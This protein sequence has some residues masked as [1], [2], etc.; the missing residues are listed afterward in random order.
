MYGRSCEPSE[1]LLGTPQH[2]SYVYITNIRKIYRVYTTN[3]LR[4]L[5]VYTRYILRILVYLKSALYS[6]QNEGCKT[7]N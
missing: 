4:I 2:V 3:I 7:T 5:V 6:T 1:L